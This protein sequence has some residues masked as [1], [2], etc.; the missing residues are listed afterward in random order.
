MFATIACCDQGRSPKKEQPSPF[1]NSP[2]SPGKPNGWH[3]QRPVILVLMITFF[4]QCNMG[5]SGRKAW[6]IQVL[7]GIEPCSR[8]SITKKFRSAMEC[9]P[10][11]FGIDFNLSVYGTVFRSRFGADVRALAFYQ[12]GVDSISW[13]AVTCGL[14]LLVRLLCSLKFFPGKSGFPLLPK[15]NSPFGLFWFGLICLL[16]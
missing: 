1:I 10:S 2:H 14:N 11:V 15:T 4:M 8:N 12:C 13:P 16:D 3:Y 6:K 7:A 5:S 9:C